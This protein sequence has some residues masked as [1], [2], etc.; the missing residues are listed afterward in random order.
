MTIAPALAVAL[1]GA[2]GA[3]GCGSQR[4]D[5]SDFGQ[6]DALRCV[7]TRSG[8]GGDAARIAEL[9]SRRTFALGAE[10][11]RG[12]YLEALECVRDRGGAPGDAVQECRSQG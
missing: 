5:R 8:E 12:G 3:T 1:A 11:Y 10:S 7:E 6:R 4:V 2:L 9:C